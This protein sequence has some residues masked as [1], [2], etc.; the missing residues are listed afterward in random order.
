LWATVVEADAHRAS[1]HVATVDDQH[2]VDGQ[3]FRI[4]NLRLDRIVA[5]VRITQTICPPTASPAKNAA[6]VSPCP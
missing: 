6:A 4:L 3:L 1:F 5:E 2:G